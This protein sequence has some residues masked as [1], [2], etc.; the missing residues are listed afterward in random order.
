MTPQEHC[1]VFAPG[2]LE[3]RMH[4]AASKDTFRRMEASPV[5]VC[6]HDQKYCSLK[7]MRDTSRPSS[8]SS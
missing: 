4:V 1:S 2:Q 7:Y 6:G 8:L 5:Q 3:V